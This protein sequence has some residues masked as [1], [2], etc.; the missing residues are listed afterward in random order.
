MSNEYTWEFGS[1][2]SVNWR[3][4]RMSK[5][6][7]C[8]DMLPPDRVDVL[9]YNGVSCSVT[10]YLYEFFLKEGYHEWSHEAEQYDYNTI[11]HWMP[12]PELPNE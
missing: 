6:I 12:L 5:W 4:E 1:L 10:C 2:M 11:S 8:S 7:S 3:E 9:V